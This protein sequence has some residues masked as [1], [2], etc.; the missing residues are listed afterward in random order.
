VTIVEFI[1][2][3]FIAELVKPCVV[4]TSF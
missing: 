3:L 4:L 1:A 2:N